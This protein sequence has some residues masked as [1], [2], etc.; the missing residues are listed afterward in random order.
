MCRKND[1]VMTIGLGLEEMVI[2][3]MCAYAPQVGCIENEKEIFFEHMDQELSA[4]PDD[5]MKNY[6]CN[7]ICLTV[8]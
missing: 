2:N 4:T 5:K 1:T 3:I 8:K 7:K 6:M